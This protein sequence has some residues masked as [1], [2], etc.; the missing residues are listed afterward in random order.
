[1]SCFLRC[2]KK[3]IIILEYP[4]PIGPFEVVGLNLLQLPR[5]S[6]GSGYILVCADH[7][8]RCVVLA[9]LRDKSAATVAH[10]L[11]SHLISPYTTPRVLLTDNGMEFMNQI[12]ADI[13]AQDGV[14]Q[15]FIT[16]HHPASNGLLER[17]TR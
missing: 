11:V 12:L 3:I 5:S 10:A 2:K 6:Q 7:F 9:P 13:C 14:K 17:T 16:T 4:I 1:M 15:P 8:S